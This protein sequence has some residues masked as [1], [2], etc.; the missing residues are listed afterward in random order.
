MR[1][2]YLQMAYIWRHPLTRTCTFGRRK[3]D[4]YCSRMFFLYFP[5]TDPTSVFRFPNASTEFVT[6]IAFSPTENLLAWTD[7]AGSLHRWSDPI[8]SSSPSPVASLST[9]ALT[10]PLRRGPTPTLFDDEA[11]GHKPDQQEDA[12]VGGVDDFENEDWI[13]D[14][15][16][17]GME[18]DA[19]AQGD[20]GNAIVKEMGMGILQCCHM[21]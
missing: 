18:D 4:G 11:I 19:D 14:D 20:D 21:S 13:L 6:Q 7:F 1:W 2:R 8:P 17:D 5:W 3:R 15:I 16:G 9:S 12:A 10:R